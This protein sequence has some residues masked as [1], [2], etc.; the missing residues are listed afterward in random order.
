MRDVYQQMASRIGSA[1][2][3]DLAA[4][5]AA[6]HDAMVKHRR[7]LAN[8]GGDP[9]HHKPD[10][11]ECPHTVAP[12]LWTRAKAVFGDEAETLTF[13]RDAAIANSPAAR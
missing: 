9:D 4:E 10:D 6:W 8:T 2:A 13:L 12:G 3:L 1:E 5:L 7:A 11:D